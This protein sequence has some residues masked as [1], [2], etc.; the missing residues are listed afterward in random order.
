[1]KAYNEGRHD[2]RNSVKD[3]LI[4]NPKLKE[5]LEGMSKF[6]CRN[7]IN[8]S[9]KHKIGCCSDPKKCYYK[10]NQLIALDILKHF[11]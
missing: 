9:H 6:D 10:Q 1:M 2:Y 4:I 7:C 3:Y 5:E 11:K 8:H